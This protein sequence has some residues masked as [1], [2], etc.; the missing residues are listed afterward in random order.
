MNVTTLILGLIAFVV[1]IF[2]L[3]GLKII[4]QC[5]TKVVER[6]GR[7]HK[8]LPSG[9]NI[10]WPI[11]D[12]PRKIY[13]R[14]VYENMSGE[15]TV[16]TK[17]SDTIDLREQVYDFPEQNVI[18]KD[19]V[20]TRINALLYFQITDPVKAVYEIDNL[21]N[22]IEKLTQTTLRNVIGE[23]ELDETLTSR[24]TINAKLRVVLDEATNKWGVKVNRVELQDITPPESVRNA[25]EKQMQ[26]ERER[27][28]KIL[29][30]EGEKTSEILRSEGD[31]ESRINM[32]EAEKRTQILRAE[33]EAEAKR[34]QAQAEAEAIQKITDAIKGTDSNPASYMLAMKYIESLKE[35]V[36]GKDNKTIYLPYE[37]TSILGSISGIKD[38]FKSK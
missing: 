37:A 10:I 35:M 33:G 19:N 38:L 28:A 1:I 22:A 11:L 8:T 17:I 5:E 26:A 25:M 34:L 12:K 3:F 14:Y 7:F 9:I 13:S 24:D 16:I 2:V 31:K 27:R 30:A 29:T 23:L 4:Q 36:S 18:T 6:L 20:T 32:A 21:P 15:R